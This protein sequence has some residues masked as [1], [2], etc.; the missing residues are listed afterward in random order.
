MT[1]R[2]DRIIEL[3]ELKE[4]FET[5]ADDYRNDTRR[6]EARHCQ[7]RF[8]FSSSRLSFIALSTDY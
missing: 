6:G 4:S 8:L 2:E 7:Q 3:G 1:L 5:P